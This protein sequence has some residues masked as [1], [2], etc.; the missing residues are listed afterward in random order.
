MI[1]LNPNGDT[2]SVPFLH[3]ADPWSALNLFLQHTG[4][5][6]ARVLRLVIHTPCWEGRVRLSGDQWV[7]AGGRSRAEMAR[8]LLFALHARAPKLFEDWSRICRRARLGDILI[9]LAWHIALRER[10]GV[11]GLQWLESDRRLAQHFDRLVAAGEIGPWGPGLGVKRRATLVEAWVAQRAP[12]DL[13]ERVRE[14]VPELERF[15][16]L[17]PPGVVAE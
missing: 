11:P 6:D 2:R 1:E 7:V 10:G 4:Y 14:F 13:A 3:D 15:G 16:M 17:A 8:K 12:R 5:G 9:K